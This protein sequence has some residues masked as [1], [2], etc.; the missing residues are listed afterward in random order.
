MSTNNNSNN[1]H[2]AQFVIKSK[3]INLFSHADV[4]KG[5][6]HK[7]MEVMLRRDHDYFHHK[8]GPD[9][10]AIKVLGFNDEN[11]GYMNPCEAIHIAP[12]MDY[13]MLYG[14]NANMDAI[15][16]DTYD[17]SEQGLIFPIDVYFT[18]KAHLVEY[19]IKTFERNDILFD[20]CYE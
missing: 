9:M 5:F 11:I 12:V 4:K 1:R 20:L 7:N 14:Y 2:M 15:I 10:W 13:M 18:C 16:T 17:W 6:I 8:R 19:A 3:I